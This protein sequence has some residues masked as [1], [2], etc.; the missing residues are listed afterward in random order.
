VTFDSASEVAFQ[1]TGTGTAPG[2]DYSQLS[3][4]GPVQLGGASLVVALGP[5]A[6]GA[7][8]PSLTPG[9][10]Y[11]LISTTGT[12]LGSFGNAPEGSELPI[13]FAKS[14]GVPEVHELRIEYHKNGTTQTVT[15]TVV[16]AAGGLP[17]PVQTINVFKDT[18]PPGVAEQAALSGAE[19]VA[20]FNAAKK[21]REEAEAKAR[22]ANA[23][24]SAVQAAEVSLAGTDV[25]V[26]SNGVALVKLDCTGNESC[27]GKLTLSATTSMAKQ[28]KKRSQ[29]ITIGTDGFLLANGTTTAAH[30][31]LNAAGRKLLVNAHQHLTAQLEIQKLTPIPKHLLITNIH[32]TQQKVY[33][34]QR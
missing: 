5:P 3:S 28:T 27:T 26:Q 1:I 24:P 19:G 6:P 11:T 20:A 17:L 7:S 32:L 18:E 8:C 9:Q 2:M 4:D 30:V 25:T 14:C 29:T 21:A 31:K 13:T 22:V 15:E 33:S 10:Q 12:L 23:M 16:P 34:K